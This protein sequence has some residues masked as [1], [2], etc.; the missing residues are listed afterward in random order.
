[1]AAAEFLPF[2]FDAGEPLLSEDRVHFSYGYNGC[3]T[4]GF[5]APPNEHHKGLG[6]MLYLVPSSATLP[7]SELRASRVRLP[8]E[9]IAVTDSSVD[10]R[11]DY[12]AVPNHPDPRL[13]PGKVHG[14]GPNA[15]FCDGHVQWYPQKDL[16]VTYNT[17]IASES[18]V[19]RM[20]NNDHEP[21]W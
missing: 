20:W 5:A 17:F 9:M 12:I 18:P 19:R 16:L 14:G 15:L 4:N 21:N 8:A 7:V 3:G 6:S 10:G 13:W 11:V 2:G 1:V